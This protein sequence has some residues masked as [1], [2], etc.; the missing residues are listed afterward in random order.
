MTNASSPGT[1]NYPTIT[2]GNTAATT[3]LEWMFGTS[4]IKIMV[5]RLFQ[6]L[7][8]Q[9]IMLEAFMVG[10]LSGV[11]AGHRNSTPPSNM[12]LQVTW[13]VNRTWPLH[14]RELAFDSFTGEVASRGGHFR[15]CEGYSPSFTYSYMTSH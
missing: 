6:W 13:W 3:C 14:F 10:V 7:R 4:F 9:H 8:D 1:K 11:T 15:I 5:S 2:I 12:T